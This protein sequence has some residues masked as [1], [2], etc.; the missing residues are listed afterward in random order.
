LSELILASTSPYRKALLQRL[1]LAFR[2][3]DPQFIESLPG[4]MPVEALV[5]HNAIGK[6]ESVL[7][8]H[9]EAT[10]IASDQ[11]AIC[12]EMVLGKP[13]TVDKAIEQLTMLSGR[14]VTFLTSLALF[15]QRAKRHEIIPYTVIFRALSE[16][17]IR[18]YVRLENPIDCAG[19][20]KS[21]GLGI[22][23]FERMHGDDPTALIGLP[24]IRLSQW[25]SPLNPR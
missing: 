3:V 18:N 2:Q 6:A 20:F 10:I 8:Q 23:L 25:L 7:A 12:D 9:P 1:G 19:S 4:S 14:S 5:L 22:A 17:E 21:E 15:N 13:G 11:L 24:L 16:T